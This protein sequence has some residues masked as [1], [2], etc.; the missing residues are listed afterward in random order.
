MTPEMQ[1]H[2][3]LPAKTGVIITE[4]FD[5]GAADEAGL[6]SQDII[7]EVNRQ[8]INSLED[9]LATMSRKTPEGA[10]LFR[11][12]RNEAFFFVSLTLPEEKRP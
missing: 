9:Y 8:K 10:Y 12:K 7:L 11:V 6:Q 2:F 4:V 5:G 1:K 3:K